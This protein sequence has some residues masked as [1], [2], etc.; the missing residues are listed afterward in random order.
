MCGLNLI[1][2][3]ELLLEL[4]VGCHEVVESSAGHLES[5]ILQARGGNLNFLT[6]E[7]HVQH[8]QGQD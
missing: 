3:V 2:V 7:N 6:R 4:L 1:A 8:H 5:A